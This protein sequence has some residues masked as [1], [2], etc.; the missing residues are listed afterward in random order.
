MPTT[1][2]EARL[3]A[4]EFMASITFGAWKTYTGTVA[5]NP[6]RFMQRFDAGV[7]DGSIAAPASEA[8]KAAMR[9]AILRFMAYNPGIEGAQL[10]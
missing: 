1:D 7:A 6:T 5:F 8:G 2:L 3:A 10:Y 4:L 9:E